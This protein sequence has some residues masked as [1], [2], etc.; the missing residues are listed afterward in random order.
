MFLP[1]DFP[2]LFTPKFAKVILVTLLMKTLKETCRNMRYDGYIEGFFII[3]GKG[4]L[5][6]LNHALNSGIKYPLIQFRTR[7]C[8][9]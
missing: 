6:I 9:R 2:G 7:I 5:K 4:T 3:H 8:I 1:I